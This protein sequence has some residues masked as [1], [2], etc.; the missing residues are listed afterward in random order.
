MSTQRLALEIRLKAIEEATRPLKL[1]REAGK[2]MAKQLAIAQNQMKGLNRA[3]ADGSGAERYRRN[4]E[5]VAKRIE[6]L[7]TMSDKYQKTIALRD[8][9]ARTGAGALAMGGA[10][11]YGAARFGAPGMEFDTEM[12]S[13]QALTRLEKQSEA[14]AK[15]RQQ[16][17]DLGASTSFTATQVAQGQGFLAMAGFN[18]DA[19]AAAMPGMLALAKAGRTELAQTADI[20]SNILTGFKLTADQTGRL[21]D[22]LVG[23]FTRS[24]V[25]LNMLGETMKYVAPV[26]ADL[27][28][29]IETAAA[30]AGKLGDAGIQGSMGGTA[31]R[32]ILSRLAAPPKMAAEALEKL[33]IKTTDAKGNLRDMPAILN[34]IAKATARMGDADRAGFLKSIAGEEAFSALSVLLNQSKTGDLQKFIET[35]RNA[36][37]EAQK[38]AATMADN[39]GGDIERI[40]SAWEGLG[41]TFFDTQEGPL[42]LLLGGVNDLLGRINQFT[43]E[44]PKLASTLAAVGT[45]LAGI[46]TVGGALLLG[47]SAVLGPLAM[48]KLTLGALAISGKALLLPVLGVVGAIG[49]LAAGAW[50]VYENWDQIKA[51]FGGVWDFLKTKASETAEWFAALPARFE[52]I[53]L[54]MMTGLSNGIRNAASGV[55]DAV[56]ST[57]TGARDWFAEKLGINSPSLVFAELGGFTM[58]GLVKG[59]SD[60]Q[61]GTIKAIGTFSRQFAATAALSMAG[62]SIA[63][64]ANVAPLV[65]VPADMPLPSAQQKR[66]GSAS[67]S[68]LPQSGLSFSYTINIDARGGADES[69]IRRVVKSELEEHHRHI[70][71]RRRSRLGDVD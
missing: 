38:N 36:T 37:G 50:L 48:A 40:K 28:V 15:L 53:G 67:A 4:L 6:R 39:V 52:R 3:L 46:V 62:A 59:L 51:W 45:A 60:G 17:R 25:D 34:D 13:V 27:G 30:M 12:A 54:D 55:K 65:N 33:R 9:M 19:I 23:T 63:T 16:A 29:N 42:R 44:N 14:L 56:V 49:L 21:G 20:A 11:L 31:L 69:A 7:R 57:A 41:I 24:N 18:P 64:A 5:E 35:L 1:V 8:N 10:A 26:A 71:A 47:V 70:D 61:A 43:T 58:D 22:I 2:Q 66:L 32:A 68:A